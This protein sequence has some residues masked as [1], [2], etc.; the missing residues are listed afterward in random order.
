LHK[1]ASLIVLMLLAAPVAVLTQT[2]DPPEGAMLII[3]DAS[4]S[5]NNLDES[6]VP[7][8]DK[9]KDAILEL[10]D[11]LPDGMQV[12]LRV[13]GHREPNT[14]QVRGCQDTELLAP[15]APLDR[16][17]IRAAVED[18]AASGFTPI[19]LS[20]Q[21]AAGDLPETG[22]RSIVLISDGED[23][24]A[25]PDPCQVAEELFG[26]LL[27]VRIESV[28]FLIDTGS[29]AEQQLRCIADVTGGQY[30]SVNAADALVA[31][32]GEVTDELLDWRPPLTL[33]GALDQLAAPLIPLSPKTDW[34]T[35]EPGKIAVR[36]F[37]SILMPGETRWYQLDLWERESVWV[38][39]DLEWPPG[40]DAGGMFETIILNSEGD[41]VE[42][43]VGHGEIPLQVELPGAESPM[44]GAAIEGPAQGWPAQA[45]YLVGFHWDA[46]SEVFLGSLHVGV[47]VLNGDAMRYLARTQI[48]GA[49]EPADAPTLA[50]AG[51]AENGP[52]WRGGEFRGP[53][54]AGETRW[55]RLDMER[56]E[57]MNTF[58]LFPGDRYVGEGTGGEF[59]I[60][61]TD[62]EGN[63]VGKPFDEWPQLSQTFGVDR[64]QATV[65]GTTSLDDDPVPESVMI[66]F[67][68]DGEPGQQSEIRFEVE[69]I[70]DSHRKLAAD[71]IEEN[72]GSEQG[73]GGESPEVSSQEPTSTTTTLAVAADEESE[74][75]GL[76]IVAVMV[77]GIVALGAAVAFLLKR[78]SA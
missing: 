29:A 50:L 69:A 9:A 73:E 25:P 10:V 42:V 24:C 2:D 65:S 56:G 22:P 57:V 6:G 52:E 62:L 51:M 35:D 23:T 11:A 39:S 41:R 17:A 30:T 21:E 33:N 1:A 78:S 70:F 13:Y 74:T 8:I 76:P 12:G 60:V 19:G 26:G 59:S 15:V 43:P 7:Y 18:V 38:W 71:Q 47:E 58:A 64:H 53:L 68:W 55:Y 32:L 63:P 16:A 77:V 44:T 72:A 34:A 5:M 27:D 31:R 48:E 54:A 37:S 61:L 40:L 49:V 4:G 45:S 36:D 66:G 14:D 75:K 20:L 28:G 67:Q 46:P 3:L